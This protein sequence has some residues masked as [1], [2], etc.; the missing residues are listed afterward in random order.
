[1]RVTVITMNSISNYFKPVA[2]VFTAQIVLEI[3][4]MIKGLKPMTQFVIC[5]MVLV[6]MDLLSTLH[7]YSLEFSDYPDENLKNGLL[8]IL[9][10]LLAFVGFFASF[11]RHLK[12]HWIEKM[13]LSRIELII[14]A[15]PTLGLLVIFLLHFKNVLNIGQM[16]YEA[17]L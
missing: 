6:F 2:V 15:L 7:I 12:S 13:N 5:S 4:R 14:N 11:S 9:I 17:G 1:V 16:L 10:C 3:F 8:M